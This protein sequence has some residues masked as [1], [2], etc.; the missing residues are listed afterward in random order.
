MFKNE[1]DKRVRSLY[2]LY[3]ISSVLIS[4]LILHALLKQLDLQMQLSHGEHS[5][6]VGT[7]YQGCA[8]VLA[9]LIV[10]QLQKMLFLKFLKPSSV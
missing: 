1:M 9:G 2:L 6:M 10:Y 4:G 7:L 5:N 3:I 8:L